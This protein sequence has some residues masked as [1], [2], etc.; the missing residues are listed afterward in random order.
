MKLCTIDASDGYGWSDILAF[1]NLTRYNTSTGKWDN[2]SA[3]FVTKE[4]VSGLIGFDD[5]I[6]GPQS[7]TITFTYTA[8]KDEYLH[9]GAGVKTKASATSAVPLPGAV[10]LL[11]SGLL[12]MIAIRRKSAQ[13]ND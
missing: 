4:N 11:G 9:F 12:G 8:T 1:T 5:Y 3:G 7:G 10:W 6:F 2:I 13:Q